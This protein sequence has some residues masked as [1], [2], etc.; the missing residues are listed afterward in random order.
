MVYFFYI[1]EI[2]QI[3]GEFRKTLQIFSISFLDEG[4]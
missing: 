4:A 2:Y 3:K 1:I